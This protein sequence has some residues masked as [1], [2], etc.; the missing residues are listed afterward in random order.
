MA[1]FP[2][3]CGKEEFKTKNFLPCLSEFFTTE[4]GTKCNEP[5]VGLDLLVKDNAQKICSTM[6]TIFA[7]S[8]SE[9]TTRCTE[10]AFMHVTSMF[11]IWVQKFDPTCSISGYGAIKDSKTDDDFS[12]DSKPTHITIDQTVSPANSIINQHLFNGSIH[13]PEFV[14][15]SAPKLDS[16][17]T[18]DDKFASNQPDDQL[19]RS[20]MQSV[21]EANQKSKNAITES[22]D[23]APSLQPSPEPS[24]ELE[25]KSDLTVNAKKSKTIGSGQI[26]DILSNLWILL[27]MISWPIII[28]LC[29]VMVLF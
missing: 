9:L 4:I 17:A 28:Q 26:S 19:L 18:S 20:T 29:T 21:P 6:K 8:A 2:L 1:L 24:P 14:S 12:L 7:C 10:Q 22:I 25:P 15:K 27:T 5:F 13:M 11:N 23:S 3:I 16:F